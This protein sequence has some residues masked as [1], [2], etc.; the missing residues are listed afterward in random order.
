MSGQ[1]TPGNVVSMGAS[2]RAHAAE[3]RKGI[4]VSV[5][6]PTFNEVRNV[7]AMVEKLDH[8]I[9]NM[10][11]EVIFVDDDSPD[12]T[13]QEVRRIAQERANVR[14]VHRIGRRGLSRAVV[15]G[16]Q[17]SCAPIAVV[18]DGDLQHDETILLQMISAI[19]DEHFDLVV[20]SRYVEGGGVGQ[21]DAGRARM[22]RLATAFAGLILRQPLSDPM[23]GFFAISRAAFL[24]RVRDLSGEGF[25]ILLDLMASGAKPLKV[26]E[27]PYVFRERQEGES[28]LDAMVL[29]EYLTLILEKKSGGVIPPKL[30]MFGLVGL[31]GMLVHFVVLSLSLKVFGASFAYSQTVATVVAM[32]GNFFVNNIFTYRDKRLRGWSLLTGLVSFLAICSFGAIANVGVANVVFERQY[33]WWLAALAGISVGTI[34]NY[35]VTAALTWGNRRAKAP[36]NSVTHS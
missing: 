24:D 8:A 21:W 13:A 27:L 20:G 32:T 22:S 30:V 35:A 4:E 18:M 34:W 19:K 36:V 9:G 15:E 11:W 16:I 17:A 25:K 7:G 10:R 2:H 6:V 1:K 3:T 26:K 14:C 28:K 33:T 23:S 5:I 12:G 31:S 29:F